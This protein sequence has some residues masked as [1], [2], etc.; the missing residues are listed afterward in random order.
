MNSSEKLIGPQVV[1]LDMSEIGGYG[2][3]KHLLCGYFLVEI[4]VHSHSVGVLWMMLLLESGGATV[5]ICVPFKNHTIYNHHLF[6][7]NKSREYFETHFWGGN[8]ASKSCAKISH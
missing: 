6:N 5:S 4:A 7:R 2:K 1:P 3:G 8:N